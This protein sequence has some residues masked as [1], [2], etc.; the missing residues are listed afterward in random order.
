M[1]LAP[2]PSL[3]NLNMKNKKNYTS[4]SLNVSNISSIIPKILKNKKIYSDSNSLDIFKIWP[5]IIGDE[6]K[7]C[8]KP[9]NLNKGILTI[10]AI[11]AV[12]IQELSLKQNQIQKNLL[13]LGYGGKVAKLKFISGNPKNFK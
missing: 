10:E 6:F 7:D 8:T 13:N 3:A 12:I 11:D 9:L 2:Q 1:N 4:K 5:Q